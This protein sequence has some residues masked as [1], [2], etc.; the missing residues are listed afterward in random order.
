MEYVSYEEFKK[1]DM[2]I[3]RIREIE[4]VPETDKL[5]RCQIDF[6]EVDGE[7][8]KVLRQIISGIKEY[9]PDVNVLEYA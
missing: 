7:G 2:R 8:N 4:A 1:M 6:G 9:Y 3:G 5:L